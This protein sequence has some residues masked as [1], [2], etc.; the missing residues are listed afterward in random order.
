[1]IRVAVIDD[2][3]ATYVNAYGIRDARGD[4]LQTDTVMYGASITKT[5]L[6]YTTLQLVDQGR[7]RLDTPLADDLDKPLPDYD[8]EAIYSDKY[9]P[10]QTLAA[11]PRWRRITSAMP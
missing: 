10:Y 3:K 2:G 1:M 5:V 4:P 9:A 8:P 11:D 6:A 7:I